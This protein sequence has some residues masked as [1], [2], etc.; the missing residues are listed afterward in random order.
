MFKRL[1]SFIFCAA[2]II[3]MDKP[4]SAVSTAPA[5]LHTLPSTIGSIMQVGYTPDNTRLITVGVMS[6]IQVWNTNTY[7]NPVTSNTKVAKQPVLAVNPDSTQCALADTL[8]K[9]A[10]L[11][12]M[13]LTKNILLKSLPNEKTDSIQYKDEKSLLSGQEKG[14]C[15]LWD[16]A[17]GKISKTFQCKEVDGQVRNIQINPAQPHHFA[18]VVYGKDQV[19]AIWDCRHEKKPYLTTPPLEVPCTTLAY[20][21]KGQLAVGG[22]YNLYLYNEKME[23]QA[24]YDLYGNKMAKGEF[25]EAQ[26]ISNYAPVL[27]MGIKF[28]PTDDAILVAPI[29]N[30]TVVVYNLEDQTK[31]FVFPFND[32]YLYPLSIDIQSDGNAMAISGFSPSNTYIYDCSNLD[33]LRAKVKKTQDA[34]LVKTYIVD[35][36]TDTSCA[37]CFDTLCSLQ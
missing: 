13:D 31:T 22:Y 33:A 21:K 17:T 3:A 34:K 28:M 14:Q 7:Q 8:S 12:I 5:I 32:K 18:T 29:D 19:V 9:K 30:N 15:N 4:Q 20:N 10:P 6:Q 23:R 11:R 36:F 26:I 35:E 37:F 24:I 2:S 16:L 27:P 25:P 1:L